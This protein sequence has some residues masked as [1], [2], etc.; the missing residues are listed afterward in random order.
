MQVC[1]I[2]EWWWCDSKPEDGGCKVTDRLRSLLR[3][4]GGIGWGQRRRSSPGGWGPRSG[5]RRPW[6]TPPAPRH[7]GRGLEW[8]GWEVS[9]SG[10]WRSVFIVIVI[11][12]CYIVITD[13]YR[14]THG[15]ITW[16]RLV[17]QAKH[18]NIA[19]LKR[20]SQQFSCKVKQML[21]QLAS[22]AAWELR[23]NCKKIS[24]VHLWRWL[25]GT[26]GQPSSTL[27]LFSAT[28][29]AKNNHL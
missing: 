4:T 10:G 11:S 29:L 7:R 19:T 6:G 16:K 1:M 9:V 15:I 8:R 27:S 25:C 17:T 5:G 20:W 26:V 12:S 24:S 22:E 18:I 2:S 28:K 14:H 21:R 13:Y 3:W 23:D